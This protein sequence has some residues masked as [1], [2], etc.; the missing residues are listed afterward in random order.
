MNNTELKKLYRLATQT[1]NS[2]ALQRACLN[3]KS[4]RLASSVDTQVL[5]L[6]NLPATEL[7]E[8]KVGVLS[9]IV[10][11]ISS[12]VKNMFET[13]VGKGFLKTFQ[14]MIKQTGLANK[15]VRMEKVVAKPSN[16]F[17]EL[18]SR[19]A[20][21][22]G[23]LSDSMAF[24]GRITSAETPEQI[25]DALD[26]SML[27]LQETLEK[28]LGKQITQYGATGYK[29]FYSAIAEIKEVSKLYTVE[30]A[31]TLLEAGII[32]F[33]VMYFGG[34]GGIGEI[35]HSLGHG[36]ME[37]MVL[38]IASVVLLDIKDSAQFIRKQDVFIKAIPVVILNDMIRLLKWSWKKTFS[39]FSAIVKN[40]PEFLSL[41][42]GKTKES[43]SN[44]YKETF[45]LASIDP[46]FRRALLTY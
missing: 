13:K 20:K 10:D 16:A 32:G 2:Q 37:V 14:S 7:K 44:L 12:K 43:L 15:I 8:V 42:Y 35:L 40:A 22:M 33:I 19:Q 41:W 4:L 5:A 1:N 18:I 3:L 23:D 27:E 26:I 45:K 25:V 17:E 34:S 29:M 46:V 6:E 9:E 30:L 24:I 11:N 21:K 36:A 28:V 38:V 31:M 39:F